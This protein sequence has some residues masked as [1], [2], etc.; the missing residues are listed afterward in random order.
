MRRFDG[1]GGRI[2]FGEIGEIELPNAPG[3]EG[4]ICEVELPAVSEDYEELV[5]R[6][7]QLA[8]VID[9]HL[10]FESETQKRKMTPTTLCPDQK[11]NLVR[12]LA[13]VVEDGVR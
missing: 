3:P 12:D 1:D 4:G 10:D 7:E 13:C 5:R 8:E 6:A 9:K 11:C 2:E